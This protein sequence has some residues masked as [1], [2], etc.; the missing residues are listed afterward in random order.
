MMADE[1]VSKYQHGNFMQYMQQAA[2]LDA[3]GNKN[4]AM[5]ALKTAYQFFPT[6]HDMHFGLDPASGDI[7][8]YG[9]NEQTGQPVANGAIHLNQQNIHGI[10]THFADPNKFVDEGVRMQELANSTAHTGAQIGL[11][12]AQAKHAIAGAHYLE[13]RNPTY[14]AG[15]EARANATAARGRLSQPANTE[16]LKVFNQ[17]GIQDPEALAVAG[18]LESKLNPTGNKAYQDQIAGEIAHMYGPSVDPAERAAWLKSKGIE[19]PGQTTARN[20]PVPNR[21]DD[22]TATFNALNSQ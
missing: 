4:G 17:Y 8:G 3:A 1:E 2:A 20:S 21:Y 6:G 7:I 14:L 19:L 18:E 9:V 5:T 11:E 10:M 13:E 22:P 15:Q 16:Y 12:N